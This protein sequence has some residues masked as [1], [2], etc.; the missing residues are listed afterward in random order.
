MT[1]TVTPLPHSSPHD[2]ALRSRGPLA[3]RIGLAALVAFVLLLARAWPRARWP[4]V[5]GEDGTEF[6]RGYFEHGAAFVL[7]PVAGYLILV[8][9][10]ITLAAVQVGLSVYPEV[11]IALAWVATVAIACVIA[12]APV[13]LRGGLLLAVAC[14]LV[15]SDAEVFGLPLYVLWWT[16]I[17]LLMLVFWDPADTGWRYRASLLAAG[18]LSSPMGVAVLPLLWLRALLLRARPLE[19][20]L[21]L[22]A[23]AF[24]ALQLWMLTHT[25]GTVAAGL[26][27]SLG[28][29]LLEIPPKFIGAY[30]IGNLLPAD[31]PHAGLVDWGAAL[32]L[33]AL[34][35]AGLRRDARNPVLWGLVALWTMSVAMSVS[36][37]SA[38]VLDPVTAGPRYFFFP[39]LLAGWLLLQLALGS[40]AA[41]IRTTSWAMLALAGAN[42][43]PVLTRMHEPLH[44][45]AHV[46]TCAQF[47]HHRL[48]VHRG[49]S[50]A[51]IWHL[52]LSAEQCRGAIARDLWARRHP[53]PSYPLQYGGELAAGTPA[54]RL[55]SVSALVR[56]DGW[57]GV[58]FET[59]YTGKPSI[60][61]DSR[62][63]GSLATGSSDAG[64]IRLRLRRGDQVWYRTEPVAR[65]QRIAVSVPGARFEPPPT[66]ATRD[67]VLL[68]FSSAALPATFDVEFTD[69]GDGWGEWSAVALKIDG[70]AR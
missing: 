61:A 32:V 22:L 24:A 65:L 37:V 4:D 36:R 66:P 16:A 62:I 42:A 63:V 30:A 29:T 19:R 8:P 15:P 9:K 3:R 27:R 52:E 41:W 48:P 47:S 12:T 33:L 54:P 67:W 28:S 23:T 70:P 35:A 26:D 11:S 21:A 20:R 40:P 69:G 53:L 2:P 50:A 34:V 25:D 18:S 14:L 56:N 49:G 43:W 1:S 44:W 60:G 46:G 57:N 55:A 13:L 58:D 39:Y 5:W 6:L 51:D 45:R 10:L 31:A 7:E 17:P 68:D 59:A 64:S 38:A